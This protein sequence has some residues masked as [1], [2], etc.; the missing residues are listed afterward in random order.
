MRCGGEGEKM[1][2]LLLKALRTSPVAWRCTA[3]V[4]EREDLKKLRRSG[5][6]GVQGGTTL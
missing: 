2:D 3:G 4:F 1:K 6:L 5:R